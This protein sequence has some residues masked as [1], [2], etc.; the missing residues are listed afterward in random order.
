[1]ASK[2]FRLLLDKAIPEEPAWSARKG[3]GNPGSDPENGGFQ[4]PLG[5][6][7]VHGEL[8]KLGIEISLHCVRLMS[9]ARIRL[10][11]HLIS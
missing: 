11:K 10:M 1:M 4:S 6:P 9:R 5:A 8:L 3:P 2:A 7:R